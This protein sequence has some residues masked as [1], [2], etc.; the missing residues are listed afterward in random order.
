MIFSLRQ[1]SISCLT[2]LSV[3]TGVTAQKP[4]NNRELKST[5]NAKSETKKADDQLQ[6][7]R[8]HQLLVLQENLVARTLNS[9]KNMDEVALAV[10]A[11]NQI[12]SY[13]W[14][15]ET[16]SQDSSATGRRIALE[17]IA[18]LEVHHSEISRFMFD[19]LSQDLAALIQ[20]HQPDLTEKLEAAINSSNGDNQKASIRSLLELRNGDVLATAKIR[21][22]LAQ[23][24]D[25]TD[26]HFSLDDPR[27]RNSKQFEP[28]LR[29]VIDVAVKGQQL[30]LD[31]L[32]W[33]SPI[34]FRSDVPLPIQRSFAEMV[35]VRTQP[36]NFATGVPQTAY[37]FLTGALPYIQQ[38]TPDLAEQA[39]GQSLLLRSSLDKNRLALEER[40]K[41]LNESQTPIED[42]V[43]EAEHEKTKF[44]HNELLA[45]AAEMALQKKKFSVC[46][47]IV[48]KIDQEVDVSGHSAFWRNWTSQFL[49]DLVKAAVTAK[50]PA[51]AEK[52]ALAMEGSSAK[53]QVVTVVIRYW[54]DQGDQANVHRLFIEA[55]KIAEATSDS[56]ETAKSFLLL[57]TWCPQIDESKRA[58]LLLSAIKA[59]NGFNKPNASDE[60]VQEFVRNLD[61]T[62]Y[63]L[64]RSFKELAKTD[65]NSAISLVDQL[66]KPDLRTFA[67]I[68]VLQGLSE[69]LKKTPGSEF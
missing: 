22:L 11:R 36:T 58:Q 65:E 39:M 33:L 25:V 60:Q 35:V 69:T 5:A 67:L 49:K 28:L 19:Y 15:T 40:R 45:E 57:S 21:Q 24:S 62:G 7:L 42:L 2:L 52:A 1:I 38:L 30:S 41:R 23:G 16:R 50:E 17:A 6:N 47:D 4:S 29:E 18:E 63:Q 14:E 48:S 27:M 26:L 43:D 54:S 64:S 10:S 8:K 37:D 53:V 9:L 12:L 44:Q 46:L 3:F 59:L 13:L 68:G 34:Y 31:T 66:K 61:N 20:K 55:S 56:V 51:I 32:F